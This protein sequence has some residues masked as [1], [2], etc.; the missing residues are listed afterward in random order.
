MEDIV[1]DKEKVK[2]N[3]KNRLAAIMEKEG[4]TAGAF[5]ESINIAQATISQIM[6]GRNM[7][8]TEILLKLHQRYPEIN[9]NWLITGQGNMYESQT[10][11]T[12]TAAEA[13][14]NEDL[15]TL[16]FDDN[17]IFPPN[18]AGNTKFSKETA[19][20][21]QGNQQQPIVKQ[22]IVYKEM[23]AKKIAEIKIFF[24]DGTFQTFKPE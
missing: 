21:N 8:S 10:P 24:D 11:E 12:A 9:L 16:P 7:P 22:E 19:F 4:L 5:A 3:V 15:A 14:Y 23:P 20:A 18:H 1:M 17:A 13:D 2:E 6:R